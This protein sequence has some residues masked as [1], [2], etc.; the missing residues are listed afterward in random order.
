VCVH[1]AN[2]KKEGRCIEVVVYHFSGGRRAGVFVVL[3]SFLSCPAF[4]PSAHTTVNAVIIVLLLLVLQTAPKPGVS[5]NGLTV[6]SK[7]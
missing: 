6:M 1:T 4:D 7:N 2:P 3:I 5:R